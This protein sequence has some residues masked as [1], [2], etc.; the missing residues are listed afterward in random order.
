MKYV[1]HKN[2]LPADVVFGDTLAMDTEFMG[3]DPWR[4][5]LCL[6]QV[7]DG[8]EDSK[9]HIV[10]FQKDCYDAPVLKNLLSEPKRKKIFYYARGDMRWISHYLG[11]MLQNV[12]CTK[13]ASRIA[14]TYTQSH[15]LEDELRAM[16]DIRLSKEKQCTYWGAET[17]DPAQLEYAC[18]DVLHLHALRAA[19]DRHLAQE[20]RGKVAE[21]LFLCIPA[22]VQADMA[23]WYNL[24]HFSYFMDKK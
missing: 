11:V 2:D 3:L 22:V 17:L 19:L 16:L 20:G 1:L 15:E 21:D 14:R 18:N 23:G 6:L 5:R 24:D 8:K 10:Q 7:Y 12:Y 9:V 4:D 13:I